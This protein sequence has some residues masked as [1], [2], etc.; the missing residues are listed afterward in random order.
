MK[1]NINIILEY[2]LIII[3]KAKSSEKLT[4]NKKN[5]N[6]T[7]TK[8]ELKTRLIRLCFKN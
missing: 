2:G 5:L 1:I 7:Q 8:K 4:N 3:P 6:K